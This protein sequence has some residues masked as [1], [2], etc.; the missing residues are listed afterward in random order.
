MMSQGLGWFR[1]VDASLG[2]IRRFTEQ[3]NRNHG[4]FSEQED[5]NHRQF[6]WKPRKFH[7]T[8]RS[9]S[10]CYWGWSPEALMTSVQRQVADLDKQLKAD[11][12]SPLVQ[13]LQ[14]SRSGIKWDKWDF[15]A[16]LSRLYKLL[17]EI[18]DMVP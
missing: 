13:W 17:G 4:R 11:S 10:A 1:D 5:Q 16:P 2:I 7:L 3:A 14:H 15:P 12:G 6:D 18:R 9:H 8:A